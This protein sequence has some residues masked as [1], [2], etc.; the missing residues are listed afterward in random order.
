M[1]LDTIFR[2]VESAE[3]AWE[4]GLSGS[5]ARAMRALVRSPTVRKLLNAV[6]KD[7]DAARVVASRIETLV[8]EID[9]RYTHPFDAAIAAYLMT[10]NTLFPYLASTL[11]PLVA[12]QRQNLWWSVPVVDNF[13]RGPAWTEDTVD[14]VSELDR[15]KGAVIRCD[16]EESVTFPLLSRG[17]FI[18]ASAEFTSQVIDVSVNPTLQFPRTV[19]HPHHASTFERLVR[20]R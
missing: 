13:L 7:N 10:L 16:T 2:E 14:S 19:S 4:L 8:G 17:D 15:K 1:L 6:R 11:G 3:F 5:R 12:Q 9:P 18:P 20:H